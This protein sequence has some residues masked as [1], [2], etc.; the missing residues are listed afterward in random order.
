MDCNLA[1][2]LTPFAG[3]RGDLSAEDAAE[4]EAHVA[5][6]A[7]CAALVESMRSLDDRLGRAMQS[8]TVPATLR[9]TIGTKLAAEQGRIWRGK[10]VRY[11]AGAAALVLV[12]SLALGWWSGRRHTLDPMQIGMSEDM[13]LSYVNART[14]EAAEGYFQSQGMRVLLPADFDYAFQSSLD[15]VVIE[16]ER[17][18]QVEFQR[19]EF[20]ARVLVFSRQSFKL[21]KNAEREAAASQCVVEVSQNEDFVYVVIFYGDSRRQHFQSQSNLVG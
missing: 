5:G 18:A 9:E 11:G 10:L 1:R 2:L 21:A 12:L 20:R 7:N 4:F 16:G 8:V 17:V 19:G 3:K 13:R 14:R 15:V 6:C